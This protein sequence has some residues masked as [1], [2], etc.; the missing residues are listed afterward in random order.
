MIPLLGLYLFYLGFYGL[1][2]RPRVT[3][4][5]LY[6]WIG[7]GIQVL[8]FFVYSIWAVG[9]WCGWTQIGILTDDDGNDGFAIFLTFIDASLHTAMYLIAAALAGVSVLLR[10]KPPTVQSEAYDDTNNR[11]N[12]QV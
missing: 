4:H 5:L 11:M 7:S 6:F 3:K 1:I 10:D 8:C 9:P 12:D 2:K